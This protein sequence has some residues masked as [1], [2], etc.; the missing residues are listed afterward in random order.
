MRRNMSG[1]RWVNAGQ[2]TTYIIGWSFARK[3]AHFRAADN[4]PAP[5]AYRRLHGSPPSRRPGPA[6]GG[7]RPGESA[8]SSPSGP[9]GDIAALT[10][11][12]D[13]VRVVVLA[14]E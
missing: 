4:C 6:D 12:L 8:P 1:S 14:H 10:G 13:R 5:S 2:K 7:N 11:R 9:P 3:W